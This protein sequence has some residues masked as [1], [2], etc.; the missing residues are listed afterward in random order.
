MTLGLLS[1]NV[2]SAIF[3]GFANHRW[4]T[5]TNGMMKLE[6]KKTLAVSYPVNVYVYFLFMVNESLLF[7]IKYRALLTLSVII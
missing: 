2:S 1:Q 5:W 4:L 3:Q 6:C 7:L